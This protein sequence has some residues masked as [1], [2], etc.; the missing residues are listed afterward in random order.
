MNREGLVYSFFS[1][2]Q[3]VNILHLAHDELAVDGKI[4]CVSR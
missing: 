3:S 1:N 4:K 2:G